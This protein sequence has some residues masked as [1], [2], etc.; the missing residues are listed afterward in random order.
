MTK[1]LTHEIL[2]GMRGCKERGRAGVL[3]NPNNSKQSKHEQLQTDSFLNSTRKRKQVMIDSEKKK[4]ILQVGRCCR[5]WLGQLRSES[6][7]S[8]PKQIQTRG[9]ATMHENGAR[10]FSLSRRCR[11]STHLC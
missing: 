2:S 3:P 4:S 7:Q 6:K 5:S 1:L 11:L 10:L 9:E 8:K